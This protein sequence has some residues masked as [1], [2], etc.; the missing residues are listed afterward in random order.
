MERSSHV[1]PSQA[2][3]L[4]VPEG[5]VTMKMLFEEAVRLAASDLLVT[6]HVPPLLRIHGDLMPLG[7]RALAP[8]ETRHLVWSL[9]NETQQEMFERKKELDFSL[10]VSGALRFRANVYYQKGYVAAAFRLV[11]RRV[12]DLDLL[13]VPQIVKE[14]TLRPHG[15]ILVTGPTGSGKTTTTAA[16]IDLIN[17]SR[18]CHIVTIEDPIEFLHESKLGVV[19]QR[20]VYADTL[21]FANALKYVLRQD[22]NVIFI[23]EMRDLETIAAAL[24]A[25]ETGHL[26]IATLHTSDAVQAIDRIVDVFPPHQ[27]TQARMQLSFSLLGVIAQQLIP[28]PDGQGR[29]LAAE[30]LI[31]NAAVAAHI[32]EGKMH[33]ARSTMESGRKE[34]MITMD[35]RLQELL[36]AEQISYRELSRRV[37]S[38]KVLDMIQRTGKR[39]GRK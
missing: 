34:G 2:E 38:H 11:P 20:E 9:L 25:A 5:P 7:S 13:G 22:P 18:R 12:A 23:G 21:S 8:E 32:R 33:L 4:A 14:L 26:V 3:A 24:T 30:V 1:T 6:A 31:R 39:A 17:S 27:Q 28:R 19:D 37:T 35:A 36:E 10:S 16:M 29:V 15:L